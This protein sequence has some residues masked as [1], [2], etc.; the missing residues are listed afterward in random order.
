MIIETD[1]WLEQAYEDRFSV[2]DNDDAYFDELDDDD[3]S[4]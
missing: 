1:D 2:D 4:E 3:E